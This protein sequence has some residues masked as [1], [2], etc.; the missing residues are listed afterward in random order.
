MKKEQLDEMIDKMVKKQLS[1][2]ITT[3]QSGQ[4]KPVRLGNYIITIGLKS[5]NCNIYNKN[6]TEKLCQ[7]EPYMLTQ[8]LKM[9]KR[10][11]TDE[12]GE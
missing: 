7:L 11:N 6:M 9:S 8:L 10:K 3:M 2:E 5:G 4:S 12:G 1:E